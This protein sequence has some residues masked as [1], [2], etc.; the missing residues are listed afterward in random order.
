MLYSW[1][2]GISG[3]PLLMLPQRRVGVCVPLLHRWATTW[4]KPDGVMNILCLW[5]TDENG[6]C[7]LGCCSH[8]G[9][10]NWVRSWS[11]LLSDPCSLTRFAG[12]KS[13]LWWA[14]RRS[15]SHLSFLLP[16]LWPRGHPGGTCL[17]SQLLSYFPFE[18]GLYSSVCSLS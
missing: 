5:D 6:W 2:L 1:S 9:S 15:R 14:C 7:G 4:W 16:G 17:P 10:N 3:C 11:V 18:R 8:Q 12:G 13:V